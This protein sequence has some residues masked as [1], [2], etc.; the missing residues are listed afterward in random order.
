MPVDIVHLAELMVFLSYLLKS[1]F[2]YSS[3][4]VSR[5]FFNR[6]WL[7]LLLDLTVSIKFQLVSIQSHPQIFLSRDF[8]LGP[9]ISLEYFSREISNSDNISIYG[10]FFSRGFKL[11]L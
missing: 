9:F 4:V 5:G 11:G 7:M 8:K 6:L 10:I 3:V 2:K 1:S